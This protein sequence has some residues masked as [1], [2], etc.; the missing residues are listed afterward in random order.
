M[1]TNGAIELFRKY[2]VSIDRSP[3]T[4][5]GYLGELNSLLS[6]LERLHN[7][8]VYLDEITTADVENFI[9]S[10]K[11]HGLAP[12]SRSRVVNVVKSFYNF[13]YKKDLVEKNLGVKLES[14]PVPQQERTFLT[15]KELDELIKAIDH[16][17]ISLVVVTLAFTGL[18]ISECLH[19]TMTDVDLETQTVLARNTKGKR[20]R[21]VPIHHELLPKLQEYRDSWRD[22]KS[23]IFFATTKS[24]KLSPAYVNRTIQEAILKLGWTKTG[25]SCHSLR[26]TFA[27]N[28]VKK[29]Q[30]IV[31][32]QKL[33]GHAKLAST[34]IYTHANTE[35]LALAVNAL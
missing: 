2:M 10:L 6:Y 24:G 12:A 14:I 19:L 20:D 28:L 1:L 35:D 11:E 4:I 32:I 22:S 18:R 31:S 16:P 3:E 29:Q 5:R 30:S 17:L 25:V 21:R 34:G 15:P 23:D 9:T 8:P 7:G 26:H 27:S 33:L 13:C